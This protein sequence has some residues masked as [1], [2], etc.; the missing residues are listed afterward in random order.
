MSGQV[1]RAI[2]Q[3]PGFHWFGYYDKLQFSED[4]RY[5]LG[6]EVNF[7]NRQPEGDDEIRVGMVDLGQGDKWVELG[8]S[9]AWAW[10]N[11]CML[12]WR[13]GYPGQIVWNDRIG[14]EFVCNILDVFDGYSQSWPFAIFCL[15]PGG[16]EALTLDFARLNDLRPGYGYAGAVDINADELA[17][18]ETGIIHLDLESGQ[19]RLLISLADLA[20]AVGD[21]PGVKDAKHYVN[22][23]LFNPSGTR[24][25]FLHRWRE[26]GGR[27]WP[28]RTRFLCADADGGNIT[29]LADKGCG[30][31]N[32]RDDHHIIAQVGGFWLLNDEG[33]WVK[34][35]GEGVMSDSGGHV[36]CLPGGEWIVSD[37][38]ADENRLQSLYLFH[39]PSGRLVDLAELVTPEIYA[40]QT[41]KAIGQPWRCDLHPRISNDGRKLCIDSVHDGRGRQMYLV[42]IGEMVE[43]KV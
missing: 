1:V 31:F 2:T 37:T 4:G 24:F 14:D 35:I 5:V 13:P 8:R 38:Y 41:A 28:F 20:E 11:G 34:R 43:M 18:D 25:A 22:C 16:K 36:S 6:M 12:Q 27:G 7:E 23:P 17:P 30:H 29:V 9:R 3:G 10:Q 19:S 15:R 39:E 42:D 21:R 40:G 33:R 32:W 26:D